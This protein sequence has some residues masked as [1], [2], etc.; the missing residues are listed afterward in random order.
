MTKRSLTICIAMIAMAAFAVGTALYTTTFAVKSKEQTSSTA[1]SS[2][3]VRD[4]SP[5]IGPQQARVT[6]VE[7]FD[8][9]CE[10]CRAFYPFVKQ[11]MAQ[12][13][14]DV[15]LVLR[16]AA[17]HPGSEE[18]IRILEAARAQNV[19][20]PVLE[21][22]L[23]AQPQWHDGDMAAAWAAARRAGIDEAK[24]RAEMMSPRINAL[25]ELDAADLKAFGIRGTPT[26]FINGQRMEKAGPQELR[27]RVRNEVASR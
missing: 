25:L 27:E 24:A 12:H 21:A 13:S 26:F 23:E 18:A 1:A 19:F 15:R 7:F 17:L 22:L 14:R 20:Q 3:L 16:Y 10:A 6:M 9:S 4:H 2:P 11:I 5:I 8:P